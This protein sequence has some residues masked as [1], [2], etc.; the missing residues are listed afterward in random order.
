MMCLCA[1]RCASMTGFVRTFGSMTLNTP[2]AAYFLLFFLVIGTGL[3]EVL[4][5]SLIILLILIHRWISFF[6]KITKNGS[7]WS[8]RTTADIWHKSYIDRQT[9]WGSCWRARYHWTIR[10]SRDANGDN[11]SLF[12]H[13]VWDNLAM[14]T[15]SSQGFCDSCR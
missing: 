11:D 2:E 6:A 14:L 1:F 10:G 9:T 8:L 3:M 13:E 12:L 15:I 5:L 4:G 7:Q